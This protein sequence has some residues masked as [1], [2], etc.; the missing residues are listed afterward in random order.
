MRRVFDEAKCRYDIVKAL[1]NVM[2]TPAKVNERAEG[3]QKCITLNHQDHQKCPVEKGHQ[4]KSTITLWLECGKEKECTSH[5]L[6]PGI[7]GD[8]PWKYE[9]YAEITPWK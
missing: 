6:L 4:T 8:S 1:E 2:I 7:R 5:L 9:L 3:I